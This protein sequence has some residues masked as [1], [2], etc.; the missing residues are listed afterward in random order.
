MTL[1]QSPLPLLLFIPTPR[2]CK[3]HLHAFLTLVKIMD[4]LRLIEAA[5]EGD[6][7]SLSQLLQEKPNL[8]YRNYL[9]SEDK[10][11]LHIS[12]MLGHE[13][14]V[15]AILVQANFPSFYYMSLAWDRD[16]RNPLHLAAIHGKLNILNLVYH[17]DGLMQAALEK[18]DRGDTILHL[19]FRYN[20]LEALKLLL[21]IFPDPF[22]AG[23]QE[24]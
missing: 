17:H 6:V 20:Q 21:Q 19:C 5:Y 15:K 8:I 24:A 10:N 9:N 7:A 23:Q 16:G 18:A 22:F 12:A 14:F 4:G 1:F 13:E 3:E 2:K 11:I